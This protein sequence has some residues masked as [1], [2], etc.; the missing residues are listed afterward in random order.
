MM[1]MG[2]ETDLSKM[3]PLLLGYWLGLELGELGE[4]GAPAAPVDGEWLS[5]AVG[6]G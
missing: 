6:D 4:L 3:L 5:V 1:E 2:M